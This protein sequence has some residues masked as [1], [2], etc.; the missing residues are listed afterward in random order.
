MKSC[1]DFLEL[2]EATINPAVTNPMSKRAEITT[3]IFFQ[4]NLAMKSTF[5]S[6]MF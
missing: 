4:L 5:L 3:V 6:K 2:E 1:K